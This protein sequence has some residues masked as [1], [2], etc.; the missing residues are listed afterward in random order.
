[1][2]KTLLQKCG[3]CNEPIRFDEKSIRYENDWFHVECFI[4]K[5][6]KSKQKPPQRHPL[7]NLK[8]VYELDESKAETPKIVPQHE[9]A[10]PYCK[11]PMKFEEKTQ[12]YKNIW[13]HYD[14]IKPQLIQEIAAEPTKI[15]KEEKKKSE[16]TRDIVEQFIQKDT[17]A[18]RKAI[19]KL[20][21]V[22]IILA[23]SMLGFLATA[24]VF[25]LGTLSVVAMI[26]GG[27]L[28]LYNLF[29]ARGPAYLKLKYSKRGPSVFITFLLKAPNAPGTIVMVPKISNALL[30]I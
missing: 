22:Q 1:L 16:A 6:K 23:C 30:I 20:D 5:T 28:I 12:R 17:E 2:N 13:F 7:L 26:F 8:I 18:K 4:I 10:C 9:P 24:S 15:P 14:C 21:P 29:T 11:K 3:Q 25:F 27:S 19:V